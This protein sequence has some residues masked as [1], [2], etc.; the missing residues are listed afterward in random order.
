VL[1]KPDKND[2]QSWEKN[3]IV[4][5]KRRIYVLNSK[6]IREQILQENYNLINVGYPRQQRMLELIKRNYWWPEIKVYVKRYVQGC[7]KCQQ[8]KIQHIKKTGELYPLEI[9]KGL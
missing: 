7:M 8:N 2:G 3:R 6:R 5:I 4:Y 9:P 1:K